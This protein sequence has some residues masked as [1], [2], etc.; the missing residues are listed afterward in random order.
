MSPLFKTNSAYKTTAGHGI[1][2]ASVRI[3]DLDKKILFDLSHKK[4]ST[5]L[6]LGAGAGGQSVRMA[7]MGS[8]VT[9]VDVYD[10]TTHYQELKKQHNL[11]DEALTFLCADARNLRELLNRKKFSDGYCN[12]MMHYLTYND[13][14]ELLLYLRE[15]ISDKLYIS[16]SGL[17][18]ELSIGYKDALMTIDQRFSKLTP[19]AQ[20]TFQILEPICLYTEDEFLHLLA[21]CGWQIA[22]SRQSDFGNIKAVCF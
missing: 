17:E 15:I 4:T 2:V 16:I 12:R 9:A 5:V 10:F 20:T 21:L 11:A 19:E 8:S 14:R 18:S 7:K 13:A 3:D 22:W 1:D 6:D